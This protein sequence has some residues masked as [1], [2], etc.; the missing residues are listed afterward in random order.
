MSAKNKYNPQPES[1]KSTYILGGIAVAVVALLVIGGV[2]WQNN[3]SAPRNDGYGTV[4][5]SAVEVSLGENG[6]VTLGQPGAPNTVDIF[7]DPMC[8]YCAELEHRSGQELAQAVD[9]GRV[10]VRYH[11]L[12]FL[13]RLSSSGDYSTRAAAASQCVAETGDAIAYSAFHARLFGSDFQP[14]ENGSADHSNDELAQLARDAGATDE[15][16]S[17]IEAGTRVEQAATAAEA[18][19]Q[20][21]AQTGAQGTPTVIVNGEIVDGLGNPEWVTEI[22]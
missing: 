5:N 20:A 16:A 10:E 15:A 14:A 17:C 4:T 11:I 2:L 22:N 6:V 9:E 18:G 19:R 12:S 8:P 13:D 1:S 7:E 3:R 21:L